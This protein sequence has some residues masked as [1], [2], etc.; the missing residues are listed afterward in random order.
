MDALVMIVALAVCAGAWWLVAKRMKANGRGWFLRNWAG[1]FTGV[2]GA[3]VL[4]ALSLEVGLIQP[5]EKPTAQTSAEAPN[6]AVV[7]AEPEDNVQ[8]V[9]LKEPAKTLGIQPA[10]YAARV[11]AVLSTLGKPDRVDASAITSGEVNDV[12][13]AKLG[14]YAA[15][16]AGIS[17]ETG[18]VQDLTVIGAGDGSPASGLE[19][20]MMASAAL[21]A[22]APGSD[23]KEVFKQLP[24]M[25]EGKSQTYG[26]V[27]VSAKTMDQL[28]TWFFAAPI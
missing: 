12:L 9:A 5:A 8:P 20:M 28:G 7:E 15:L 24:A 4:V 3:L 1:S 25:M 2:F 10:D 6:P 21:S 22:A 14:P 27:E 18:E 23:F 13:N 19:I 17:K 16:I 11:N 26:Q